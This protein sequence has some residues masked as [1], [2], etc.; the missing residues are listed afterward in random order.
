MKLSYLSS[1]TLLLIIILPALSFSQIVFEKGYIVNNDGQR[2]EC[3]IKNYEWRNGPNKVEYR[4]DDTSPVESAGVTDIKGFGVSNFKYESHAVNIDLSSK[5]LNNLSADK[6]PIF[7]ESTVFLRVL[8][9]GDASLYLYQDRELYFFNVDSSEVTPLIHKKYITENRVMTNNTFKSQLWTSLKCKDI[10]IN[11]I[12]KTN[13]KAA[14][15]IRLFKKYNDCKGTNH[16]TYEKHKKRDAFNLYINAGGRF[17]SF[18]MNHSNNKSQNV[19]FPN[20]INFTFGLDIEYVLPFNKNKWA[21]IVRPVFQ[22]YYAEDPRTNY[23]NTVDYQSVEISTG[24]KYNFFLS[25]VSKLSLTGT[26]MAFDIPINSSIGHL[27]VNTTHNLN[28]GFGYAF[29]NR[30]SVEIYYGTSRGLLRD[31]VFYSSSYQTV[32]LVLGVNI[33]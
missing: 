16:I 18:R 14:D 24:I 11:D 17:S 9:E 12:E 21:V 27:E 15:L 13:Y 7:E 28:F 4:Y 5:A 30:Y 31:Y 10:T 23:N 25:D 26:Y 2:I 22:S 8:H 1:F 32:S 29:R 3:L 20:A 6:D 19:N 33:F